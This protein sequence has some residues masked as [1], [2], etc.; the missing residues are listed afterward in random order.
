MDSVGKTTTKHTR[1]NNTEERT[2]YL[3]CGGRLKFNN[4]MQDPITHGLEK[5]F[6]QAFP[7]FRIW[8]SVIAFLLRLN[9]V[10]VN[11]SLI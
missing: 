4:K 9:Y 3:H 11:L 7:A 2:P 8:L 1:R 5:L 6:L 10:I